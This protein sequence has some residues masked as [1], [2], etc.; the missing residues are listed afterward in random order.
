M[1]KFYPATWLTF[2]TAGV[3]FLAIHVLITTLEKLM[4]LL[5]CLILLFITAWLFMNGLNEKRWVDA[6]SHDEAVAADQG[7]LPGFTALT[8]TGGGLESAK[9]QAGSKLQG[10]MDKAKEGSAK[11]R[12]RAG[13]EN[14]SIG[15][16]VSKTKDA[17]GKAVEKTSELS[18]KVMEKSGPLREKVAE[19]GG[20]L[21]E[22]I[23]KKTEEVSGKIREKLS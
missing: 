17:T 7:L 13:D 15:K 20:P 10:A 18:S 12:D 9:S 16:A 19:K 11:L 14:D 5:A 1:D 6:H 22:Q 2:L 4:F 8:G 21:W 23:T 3:S